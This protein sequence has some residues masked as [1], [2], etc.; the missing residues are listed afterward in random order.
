MVPRVTQFGRREGTK[1]KFPKL[2]PADASCLIKLWKNLPH[3]IFSWI[4]LL[5]QLLNRKQTSVRN[6][7]SS[8]SLRNALITRNNGNRVRTIKLWVRFFSDDPKLQESFRFCGEHGNFLP[9]WNTTALLLP[10]MHY[11][12][13]RPL[14]SELILQKQTN[15][16]WF[17]GLQSPAGSSDEVL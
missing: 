3:V 4:H 12:D 8:D 7:A 15:R 17:K 11:S 9:E 6:Q 10:M 1:W 16:K 2:S 14:S 5:L 13:G